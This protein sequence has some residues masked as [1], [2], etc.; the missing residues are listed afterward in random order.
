MTI[1]KYQYIYFLGIGGI[2]MSAL[3]RWFKHE[4]FWVGGYD[5]TE[6]ALT[7]ALVQESMLVQYDDTLEALPQEVQA[8]KD[9]TL[10]VWTPAIPADSVQLQYLQTNGYQ[11]HKRAEVLGWLTRDYFTIAVAGTHG[12]TTTSSM[13]AHILQQSPRSCTAFL[14]GIL[15][16]YHS[17]MLLSAQTGENQIVVV[18]ADEYDKSFL[19]LTP[20]ILVITSLDADHLDI[21]GS[22]EQM[23]ETYKEFV[24]R[25]TPDDL[26]ILRKGLEKDLPTAQIRAKILTYGQAGEGATVEA[27]NLHKKDGF[28]VATLS[29]GEG[30]GGLL[31]VALQ[32]HGKYNLENAT[33]AAIACRDFVDLD[34]I[35]DSL[36]TFLGAERRFQY[37][38]KTDTAVLIDDYAHHPTEVQAFLTAVREVYPNK[39]ITAIFQPHLY[40]RTR[41]FAPEFAQSFSQADELILLDIYPAR[42]LPLEG[43]T[44][45]WLLEQIPLE[46]HLK[47]KVAILK[48]N[49]L[50]HLASRQDLEVVLTIGAGD[51]NTFLPALQ[52]LVGKSVS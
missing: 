23:L 12:K 18:E 37:W 26:L 44:S 51:V 42:E 29:F 3:A 38:L 20:N 48:E 2:G 41:D 33:A 30:K 39:R 43:I 35:Q 36:K 21:Y 6:T 11:L 50:M 32:L 28:S 46:H 27:H 15:Q 13:I 52:E 14:G 40:S 16:N 25:L 31:P 34:V 5:R 45:A 22:R 19:Q 9:K 4:G 7:Q 8:G 24:L 10:V 1:G 47:N 17:N 49:L